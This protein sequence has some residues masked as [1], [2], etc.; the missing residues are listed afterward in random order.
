MNSETALNPPAD[1]RS[2]LRQLSLFPLDPWGA[3]Y[4][5]EVFARPARGIS[6]A[7]IGP[8]SLGNS[9]RPGGI[10]CLAA[11]D[12]G[13]FASAIW[14]DRPQL[15]D[16][17]IFWGKVE[18]ELVLARHSPIADDS[19]SWHLNS[20]DCLKTWTKPEFWDSLW[21]CGQ[22]FS[23][24]IHALSKL[25]KY[26]EFGNDLFVGNADL[27]RIEGRASA[28]LH[29]QIKP[30][31]LWVVNGLVP[32]LGSALT[33]RPGL[34]ITLAHQIVSQARQ[35]SSNAVAYALQALRTESLGVLH[36]I[37][38]GQPGADAQRIKDAIFGGFSVPDAFSDIG[39]VKATYRRT[40]TSASRAQ[41]SATE[42]AASLS[43]LPISGRD[44][45]FAMRLTTL[46]P[47]HHM[48]EFFEFSRLLSQIQAID[49]QRIETAPR[50]LQW[51]I[52]PG[53]AGSCIRLS[54]LINYARAL[55]GACE[56]LVGK[57][58]TVDET[59]SATLNWV[60]HLPEGVRAGSNFS[61]A[62]D[63]HDLALML[64]GVSAI[65][66]HPMGELTKPIFEAHPGFSRNVQTHELLMLQPLDSLDL[67]M[68]HGKA[69]GN[70][71][72]S[73]ST[74]ARYVM[75]GAA[76]YGVRTKTGVAGTIALRY[77]TTE[78]HP[79]V[80]VQEVSG[81][82]N[83]PAGVDLCSLAQCLAESWTTEEQVNKWTAYENRCAHWRSLVS[84]SASQRSQ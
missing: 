58:V 49:F 30:A 19:L 39:I 18:K 78:E 6:R 36:L 38:S 37:A 3:E 51:C 82:T 54:L 9:Y 41:D 60:Q 45:L 12:D 33:S 81:L 73:P 50:L 80:E 48:E 79:K 44:W 22:T 47:F 17:K 35:H 8:L 25:L 68:L 4:V 42:P 71:L 53:H 26:Y 31:V 55:I 70:C 46:A 43:N 66:S 64:S 29:E 15:E 27:V 69:C 13:A 40:L 11:S 32:A 1:C 83:S 10:K 20:D 62:L 24:C 72:K 56:R 63:P 67:A 28:M 76:L 52:A 2:E 14:I 77:D 34:S 74:V 65:S 75:E 16:P 7:M 57:H 84:K 59:V 5:F 61:E 23:R 21:P